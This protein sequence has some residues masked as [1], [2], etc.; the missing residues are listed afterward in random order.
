LVDLSLQRQAVTPV[1]GF[2]INLD[3]DIGRRRMTIQPSYSG[4]AKNFILKPLALCPAAF[5]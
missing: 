3:I 5:F 4:L 2:K 1:I